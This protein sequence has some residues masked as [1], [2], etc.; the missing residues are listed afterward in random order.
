MAE[1]ATAILAYRHMTPGRRTG[2]STYADEHRRLQVS[3]K[4]KTQGVGQG[5]AHVRPSVRKTNRGPARNRL[6]LA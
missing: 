1:M 2:H 6:P 3:G 4:R 5:A